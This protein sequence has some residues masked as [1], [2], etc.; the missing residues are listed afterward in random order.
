MMRAP[1][2][3]VEVL[4][5]YDMNWLWCSERKS[6][7]IT[8]LASGYHWNK[9]TVFRMYLHVTVSCRL[10]LLCDYEVLPANAQGI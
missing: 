6:S 3:F 9:C 4:F 8:A 5:R 1:L 10:L 2:D 7:L